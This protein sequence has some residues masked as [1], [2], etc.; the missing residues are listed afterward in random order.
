MS[1]QHSNTYF[2]TD[3]IITAQSLV[4]DLKSHSLTE[5]HIGV[6]SNDSAFQIAE[7]PDADIEE[8]TDVAN[9]AKRGAL[10][11][12]TTG[13][14]AGISMTVFPPAG[15]ALGGTA[16]AGMML[17][18]AAVGTWTASMIGVSEESS[19]LKKFD[20]ALDDN[21]F[22]VLAEIQSSRQQDIMKNVASQ[23]NLPNDSFGAIH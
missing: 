16:I 4:N 5:E 18:G 11:G 9:A 8:S 12:S 15:V 23:N 3:D 21:A 14:L 17:G 10:L 2:I 6:V 22:L 13:L 20:E 1:G 19:L 7:L